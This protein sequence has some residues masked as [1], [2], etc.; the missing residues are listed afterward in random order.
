[1]NAGNSSTSNTSQPRHFTITTS[2]TSDAE[3]ID[4]DSLNA[5][6]RNEIHN[7]K[8]IVDRLR[9]QDFKMQLK[10][11]STL[12]SSAEI[13]ASLMKDLEIKQDEQEKL[14]EEIEF[15]HEKNKQLQENN[16]KLAQ[17][18][19]KANVEVREL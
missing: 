10:L 18:Y 11:Q 7:L 12:E 1:M 5:K 14:L 8:T 9:M 2:N 3:R 19:V 6:L 16:I 4:Y 13:T 17:M 15:L